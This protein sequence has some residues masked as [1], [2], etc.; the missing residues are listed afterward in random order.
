MSNF[1]PNNSNKPVVQICNVFLLFEMIGNIENLGNIRQT[2]D[3]AIFCF[4]PIY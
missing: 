4:K 3:I 2:I 1:C